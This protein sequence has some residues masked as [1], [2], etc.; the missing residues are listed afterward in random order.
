M[1]D[2]P[3]A[4]AG[5][6]FDLE[7]A[8]Y[9]PMP[10]ATGR[11]EGAPI[12][13][14]N[15]SLR[16]AAGGLADPPDRIVV[17]EYLDRNGQ[18]VAT[19]E[20]VTLARAG[21]D[22]AEALAADQAAAERLANADSAEAVAEATETAEPD[23]E[24]A[25]N[26]PATGEGDADGLDPELR[27][28]LEHPQVRQAIEQRIGEVEQARQ[29]YLDGLAAATKIAQVSFLSQF[30]ELAAVAPDGMSAALEQMS[31]QDP[32]K[33]A[34]VQALVAATEQLFAEQRQDGL[35]QAEAS[36]RGFHDF[37]R[38]EDA[39]FEA[40]LKGEAP[41]TRRAVADEII[42][43]AGA[44]GIEADELMRLFDSEPIMRN[45]AFQKMMY[46]AG[47][48]R[49]LIKA[50]DAAT[51]RAVPSVQRPGTARAPAERDRADLRTLSSRLSNSGNIRDAVALYHARKSQQ[52]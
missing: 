35:R 18:P 6:A 24:A 48:Y 25:E 30:P 36:R 33:F 29:G 8:G 20:A 5:A 45:S 13:G 7:N 26:D 9:V 4:P 22:Y 39:R 52:R 23:T 38:S 27:K 10:E 46:E 40:T 34:R 19:N 3:I 41:E 16:E 51:T 44:S 21:R 11:R 37:A 43:A 17:R 28:A 42:A 50:R 15:G 31:R 12:G 2:E 14:D 47:K 49:L 1:A 32:A